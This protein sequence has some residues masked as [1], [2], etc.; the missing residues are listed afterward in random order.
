[1][2]VYIESVGNCPSGSEISFQLDRAELD[3]AILSPG[4][5]TGPFTVAGCVC[6]IFPAQAGLCFESN[7][8]STKQKL[9]AYLSILLT[10]ALNTEKLNFCCFISLH[11]ENV[12]LVRVGQVHYKY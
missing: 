1:M 2:R 7:E 3:S 12:Q 5:T 11:S 10:S 4:N 8:V 9:E 6:L